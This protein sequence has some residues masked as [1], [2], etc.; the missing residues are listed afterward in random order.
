MWP[1]WFFA[2]FVT[3]TWTLMANT[4][5]TH[6]F[7]FI[8]WL[9]LHQISNC[10]Y[11]GCHTLSDVSQHRNSHK[12]SPTQRWP[13]SLMHISV[14]KIFDLFVIAGFSCWNRFTSKSQ[15]CEKRFHV[16]TS[17]H[18]LWDRSPLCL[19]IH[20][21]STGMRP[22]ACV[23]MLVQISHIGASTSAIIM[24]TLILSLWCTKNYITLL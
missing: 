19:E 12:P 7:F 18:V 21:T 3:E 22:G 5:F 8:N 24:L 11:E 17:S 15:W 14:N 23:I 4:P 20:D 6:M 13:S 10:I 2:I 16:I 1:K 9:Y